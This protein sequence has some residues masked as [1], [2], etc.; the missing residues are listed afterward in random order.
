MKPLMLS[1]LMCGMLLCCLDPL[2]AQSTVMRSAITTSG[3]GRATV[4]G[5]GLRGVVGVPGAGR[6]GAGTIVLTGGSG[7]WQKIGG[8][9]TSADRPAD[10]LVPSESKLLQNYPNPFNPSTVI[11][12]TISR[13]DHVSLRVYDLL[14]R[15]VAN[16]VDEVQS[17]GDHAV[18]F[19]A[20][21]L[22]SGVYLYRL[23]SGKTSF[24][25]RLIL[26]R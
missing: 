19:E 26:L 17:P 21:N 2:N 24:T 25:R 3:A 8:G 22:A 15:E 5:M 18:R 4:G 20:A 11:A 12:Y 23:E 14:G 13:S 1:F 10:A 16:L 9:A 7:D 6:S